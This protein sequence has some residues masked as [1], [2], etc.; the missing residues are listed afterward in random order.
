MGGVETEGRLDPSL[1][2][3]LGDA[4]VDPQA[5]RFFQGARIVLATNDVTLAV[6]L[7]EVM[8]A[9]TTAG[10][11]TGITADLNSTGHAVLMVLMFLGRVG[12]LT[13]GV[14]LVLRERE[15]LYSNPEERP[16]IG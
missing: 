3:L 10:L 13:L 11:S 16:L 14:A 4:S 5:T 12:P 2:R 6:A 15:R 1:T 8:A 7:F 9:F